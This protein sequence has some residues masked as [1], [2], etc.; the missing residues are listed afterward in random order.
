MVMEIAEN[1][2]AFEKQFEIYKR[3]F[4]ELRELAEDDFPK[5]LMVF[6]IRF[7]LALSLQIGFDTAISYTRTETTRKTYKLILMLNELW[8]AYEGLYRLCDESGILKAN[9]G[10]PDPFTTISFGSILQGV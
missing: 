3:K 2:S 7:R 6:D 5:T 9:P 8:F 4:A 1:Q 10:K